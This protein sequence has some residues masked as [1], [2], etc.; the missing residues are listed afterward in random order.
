MIGFLVSSKGVNLRI[1]NLPETILL[2]LRD[3]DKSLL[4]MGVSLSILLGGANALRIRGMTSRFT[5]DLDSFYS[6]ESSI[7]EE[8]G[9]IAD[10]RGLEDDWLNDQ[11]SDIPLPD[12]AEDTS[13]IIESGLK[14]IVIKVMSR[15]SLLILKTN[16]AVIRMEER[17]I[18]DLLSSNITETE[19]NDAVRYILTRQKPD[20]EEY[21]LIQQ[22]DIEE[23]HEIIFRK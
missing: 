4:D 7:K 3:L 14:R 8:I 16:A 22:K 10:K 5:R 12:N 6:I 2:A 20:D 9:K 21:A 19:F 18:E 17:D 13:E 23:L 1:E 11:A 15:R